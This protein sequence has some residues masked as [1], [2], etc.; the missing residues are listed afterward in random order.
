MEE[1]GSAVENLFEGD[2]VV[3]EPVLRCVDVNT[4]FREDI[5]CVKSLKF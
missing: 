3:V 1:V 4:A 2:I 5:T